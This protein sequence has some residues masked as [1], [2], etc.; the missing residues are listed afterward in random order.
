MT[1]EGTP[2]V[3][4]YDPSQLVRDVWDLLQERGVAP[5]FPEGRQGPAS[6]AAGALLRSL[7]VVPAVDAETHYKGSTERIWGENQDVD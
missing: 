3:Q 4:F 5:S 6:A 1:I 7:G 2:S